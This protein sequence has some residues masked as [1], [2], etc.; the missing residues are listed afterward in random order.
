MKKEERGDAE[1]AL[2]LAARYGLKVQYK[3]GLLANLRAAHSA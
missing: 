3:R 1:L 2:R